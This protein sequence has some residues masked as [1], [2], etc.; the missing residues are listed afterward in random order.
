[1]MKKHQFL[2]FM[3]GFIVLQPVI[4][5]LTSAT[6]TWT[7]SPISVG[8]LLRTFYFFV[9]AIFITFMALRSKRG[10]WYLTYLAGLVIVIVSNIVIN[11]QVKNPYY[12]MQELSFFNKAVYF[13]VML[14]G[15]LLILEELK[16]SGIDVKEHV[17]KLFLSSSVIISFVFI[18]A[19]LTGTSMESYT[20]SKIGWTG[21]FYAGNEIGGIMAI[22]VPITAL[23]AIRKTKTWKD[24]IWWL[25]F[26]ALSL[27][28]L[29]LGT[30]V[31][32]AGII[33][34]LLSAL[35][36]SLI[37]LVLKKD[38]TFKLNALMSS[39]FLGILLV[40]TPFTPVFQNM[41]AHFDILGLDYSKD[42]T[43]EET[44]GEEEEPE[45]I[46]DEQFQ[47]LIFSSR[48]KYAE[49]YKEQFNE[50]PINQKLIGMGYAG[51]YEEPTE[52]KPLKIIEMDF[53][54]FF[55]SFGI[56][57]FI[58]LVSPLLYFTIKYMLRFVMNIKERFDY[59]TIF[60]GISCLLALG[61]SFTAGHVLTAPSVSI[62]LASLL[63]L[64][65]VNSE[66]TS[67]KD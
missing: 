40:A 23:Y 50:A 57:G 55:Y 46:S 43:V 25:P 22:L 36:G 17:I 8:I 20:Y 60:T 52:I 44:D 39:L 58:Y 3:V 65:I 7:N 64:L 41:Y 5:V 30:K 33:I 32:Y 21:W 67:K 48:E 10:K 35:F 56:I 53:H 49:D 18:V 16:R 59:F 11:M 45:E 12:L 29:A 13:H 62:Y 1:M 63:A 19:Q 54:D 61:I 4:D 51:N 38:S 37:L 15:F 6:L 47:N 24:I 66:D 42:K 34:V 27:S 28:M 9:M 31:G 26:V 2:L 14:F